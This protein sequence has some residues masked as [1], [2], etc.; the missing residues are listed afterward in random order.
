MA[1]KF[2]KMGICSSLLI[3]LDCDSAV[4]PAADEVYSCGTTVIEENPL[5]TEGVSVADPSGMPDRDCVAIEIDPDWD[6]FELVFT[7]C[8]LFD[9]SF[10]AAFGYSEEMAGGLGSKAIKKS[11]PS[12]VCECGADGCKSTFGLATWSLAYCAGKNVPHPDGK[13]VLTVYPKVVPR[14]NTFT[15]T[16]NRE[17]NGRQ[18]LSRIYENPAFGQGIMIDGQW[19]IPAEEVPFDRCKYEYVTD[20]CP[21]D[22]CSCAVCEAAIIP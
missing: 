13:F 8:S 10:D 18:Y 3:P 17:L 22:A 21:P 12:C 7:T 6:Q 9:T 11:G 16:V 15:R 1:I 19:L 5:L 2:A 4:D 14:P 20:L